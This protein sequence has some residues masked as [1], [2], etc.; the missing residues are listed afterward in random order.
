MDFFSESANN[1]T[2]L[3][4]EVKVNK[5]TEYFITGATYDSD[6][7]KNAESTQQIHKD[8]DD[9]FNDIGCFEVTFSLQLMPECTPFQAPPRHII[10]AL[11]K[12]F[13]DELERLQQGIIT[14]LGSQQDIGM[15]QHFCASVQGKW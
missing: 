10:Y 11:Q 4:A 14:H 9:V 15:V 5:S 12:P 7:R 3:K 1:N 13:Q 2:K 6:K 8:H